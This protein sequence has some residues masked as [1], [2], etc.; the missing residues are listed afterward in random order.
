[1]ALGVFDLSNMIAPRSGLGRTMTICMVLLL[2]V[3]FSF[4]S[5]NASETQGR[6]ITSIV[7]NEIL[8]DPI[9][10]DVSGEFVELYNPTGTSVNIDGWSLTDQDGP[11]PDIIFNGLSFPAH[12]FLIVFTGPGINDTDL[13]DGVGRLYLGRSEGIWS[14][15]GDDVL[16]S[17]K[18][19]HP[20]D[21]MSYGEGVSVDPPPANSTWN[22]T[23]PLVPEGYSLGRLPDGNGTIGPG[24][25]QTLMPTPGKANILDQPPSIP[26]W[27]L[28]PKSPLAYQDLLV[29]S[30]VTDDVRVDKVLVHTRGGDGSQ[31]DQN[32]TWDQAQ[33]RYKATIKGRAGGQNLEL[34]IIASNPLAQSTVSSH[35]NI[36]FKIN[37]S[38]QLVGTVTGPEGTVLPGAVFR[39]G[40]HIL[41]LNGSKVSGNVTASIPDT[42]GSWNATFEDYIDLPV[43][44]PTVEG[45]YNIEVLVRSGEAQVEQKLSVEV[46]WPFKTLQCTLSADY[47][48]GLDFVTGQDIILNG[49][50]KFS[51]GLPAGGAKASLSIPGT[52]THLDIRS[53]D[54][55]A[56]R[57]KVKTPSIA[58]TYDFKLEAQ[59]MGKNAEVSISLTI[60]DH[61]YLNFSKVP[62]LYNS[63]GEV[64]TVAGQAQHHDG[65]PASNSLVVIEFFGTSHKVRTYTDLDGKFS[66][67]M[68]NPYYTGQYNLRITV[69]S[70]DATVQKEMPLFIGEKSAASKPT[71]GWDA[72]IVVLG[73]LMAVGLCR[74][75]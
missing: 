28:E 49:T 37:A 17:D 60:V 24:C 54:Q 27:D 8:Y 45:N 18:A 30:K 11:A 48:S 74:K 55:G 56:L 52:A 66:A 73:I 36:T 20:I 71:P 22:W 2:F 21:Y 34:W 5:G 10:S 31:Q 64:V 58:G 35:Q 19:D 16:L 61:L 67:D 53:N 59:A 15:T 6:A 4:V 57:I 69:V 29:W 70:G 72:V 47:S 44:A 63:K 1:M 46:R 68:I 75:R 43:V 39:L 33:T 14:N 42:R 62:K 50:V 12:G 32:M 38:T 41:W 51:D 3:P 65:K 9:G 25:Y 23:V 7:I 13:T 26:D 40:G